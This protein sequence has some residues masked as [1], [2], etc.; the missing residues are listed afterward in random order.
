MSCA[1]SPHSLHKHTNNRTR[2]YKNGSNGNNS[3]KDSES[4]GTRSC[5]ASKSSTG[6]TVHTNKNRGKNIHF[7]FQNIIAP[8][9]K[10]GDV[11]TPGMAPKEN[12]CSTVQPHAKTLQPLNGLA[13][14]NKRVDKHIGAI[15]TA[16]NSV[17]LPPRVPIKG[18]RTT[19][20]V[21]TCALDSGACEA[22]LA[23]QAF[24]NTRARKGVCTGMKH[25]EKR[26]Q[27]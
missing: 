6:C 27:T 3:A 19:A 15:V 22:V 21:E 17:K 10:L 1:V 25:Q 11:R 20:N 9:N 24:A 26:S 18:Y 4:Y 2:T 14:G 8:P 12:N 16:K 7:C 23:P 5:T 13:N